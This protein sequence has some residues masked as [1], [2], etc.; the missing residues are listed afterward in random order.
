M[1]AERDYV[2]PRTSLERELVEIWESV[3]NFRPIGIRSSFFALGGHSLLS[4]QL[5]T[6]VKN[7]FGRSLPLEVLFEEPT[8]EH[9]ADWLSGWL[10]EGEWAGGGPLV[11]LQPEGS[12][13][14]FY[15]VHP[16]GG[17]VQC[18]VALAAHLGTG[19]PFHALQAREMED[20]SL[21]PQT[22]IEEM[23][24]TY[25]EAMRQ[26]QPNGPYRLGG[27]SYGGL[28]AFEMAQQLTRAGERVTLLAL[29]DATLP[30]GDATSDPSSAELIVDLVASL[31]P[32]ATEPILTV[33]E[34]EGQSLEDQL[35]RAGEALR[36]AGAAG[37]GADLAVLRQR[38]DG[39][40]ARRQARQSYR[41]R[42]YPGPIV[43]FRPE[44]TF[45]GPAPETS[46]GHEDPTRFWSGLALGGIDVL[47]VPGRHE[48]MCLEPHVRSLAAALAR[49]LARGAG[50]KR[51]QA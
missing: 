20:E 32:V 26:V 5:L 12:E 42:P 46:S 13:P 4:L 6:E 35:G 39:L 9:L 25:V 31:H 40:L 23:A 10:E 15:C 7:R 36:R 45:R 50:G 29:I 11:V 34:L 30:A 51:E 44:E 43:L 19:Q 21:T 16:A 8:I 2:A 24:A 33:A 41:A 28:V 18:Y 37:P 17:G 22:S 47:R 49:F 3:L 48:A 1:A 14:P 27:W 38:W